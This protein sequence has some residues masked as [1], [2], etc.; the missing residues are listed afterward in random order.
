[1]ASPSIAARLRK[2]LPFIGRN[3]CSADREAAVR[4]FRRLYAEDPN[5]FLAAYDREIQIARNNYPRELFELIE[6][7]ALA[8]LDDQIVAIEHEDGTT[9]TLYA[10]GFLAYGLENEPLASEKLLPDDAEKLLELLYDEYFDKTTA[11]VRIYENLLPLN[12]RI[13]ADPGEAHH[14]LRLFSKAKDAFVTTIPSVDM[15]GVDCNYFD[16]DESDIAARFRVILIAV[17]NTSPDTPTMKRA[18][19]FLGFA[20]PRGQSATLA[21][22]ELLSTHW[23]A[24]CLSLI[25]NR[26]GRGLRYLI[27]EPYMFN[28]T[29][30]QLDYVIGLKRVMVAFTRTALDENI[31]P[32][33]LIVS[34][35][36]FSDPLKGYSELR[37]AFARPEA[38]D[39]LLN[40]VPIPLPA[41]GHTQAA[42][43]EIAA[44]VCDLF[45]LEGIDLKTPISTECPL[46]TAEPD[47]MDRLYNSIHNI[48]KPL[49]R[50]NS[51][52]RLGM[53]S[54]LLN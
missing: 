23:G 11:K 37:V 44:M 45:T 36:A 52:M 17:R 26:C 38:P 41:G 25:S 14:F 5:G 12:H 47:T 53:P 54:M 4:A 10:I 48:Q 6:T 2:L 9:S 19:S 8:E 39:D 21:A 18:F 22:E 24:E 32:D 51:T 35:G 16:E 28:D 31:S 50:P 13:I 3:V 30:R 15:E 20:I 33:R 46:L 34:L 49:K 43:E 7:A 27:T 29:I 42:I 40:G 1:M